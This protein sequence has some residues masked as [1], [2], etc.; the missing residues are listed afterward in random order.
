MYR[1]C[2][3][4]FLTDLVFFFTAMLLLQFLEACIGPFDLWPA[5]VLDT[6]FCKTSTPGRLRTLATF[7]FGYDVP[8]GVAHRLYT[9][10]KPHKQYHYLVPYAMG[11]IMHTFTIITMLFIWLSIM[12]SVEGRCCGSMVVI[13]SN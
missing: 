10:C 2:N 13:I 9:I 11:D 4:F 6:L 7:F 1:S 3:K 12:M 5:Y 8:L